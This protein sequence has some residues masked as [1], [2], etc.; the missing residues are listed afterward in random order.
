MQPHRF[1]L[2]FYC[3]CKR[4][5][6]NFYAFRCIPYA[7]PPVRDQ[8]SRS[9]WVGKVFDASREEPTCIQCNG[10]IKIFLGEEDC[11]TVNVYTHD[12]GFSYLSVMVYIHAGSWF[13]GSGNGKTDQENLWNQINQRKTSNVSNMLLDLWTSLVHLQKTVYHKVTS[14]LVIGF[15]PRKSSVKKG[16]PRY[17]RS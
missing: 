2:Q 13:F 14:Y 10:I 4:K 11:L 17:L 3:D 5:S 12:I 6:R 8:R 7:K 1:L 16:S 15:P 9:A